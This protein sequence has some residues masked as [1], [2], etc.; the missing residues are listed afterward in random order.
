MRDYINPNDL[1]AEIGDLFACLAEETA[2]ANSGKVYN[3]TKRLLE[4]YRIC[5]WSLNYATTDIMRDVEY[6]TNPGEMQPYQELLAAA[7][8]NTD[9]ELFDSKSWI[10]RRLYSMSKTSAFLEYVNRTARSLQTYP[11]NG[12]R[13]YQIL[14]YC[15]LDTAAEN[16]GTVNSCAMDKLGYINEQS[17]YKHKREAI[18]LFASL[19]WDMGDDLLMELMRE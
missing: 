19:F 5:V 16:V 11:Y 2:K 15:Y 4:L 7:A 17:Y 14:Y 6:V 12:E 3:K 18:S 10:S 9:I 8:K 13:Y 1:N